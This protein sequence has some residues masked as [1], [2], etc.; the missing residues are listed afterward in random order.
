MTKKIRHVGK[1]IPTGKKIAVVFMQIPGNENQALVCEYESFPEKLQSI[2]LNALY[3]NEAQSSMSLADILNKTYFH[4]YRMNLLQYLH[5]SGKL[6][7]LDVENVLMI[8]SPGTSIKL[9]VLIEE[10]KKLNMQQGNNTAT[11]PTNVQNSVTNDEPVPISLDTSNIEEIAK[12]M[13]VEVEYLRGKA[14]KL[15]K[16]AFALCP[17]LTVSSENK[18]Q[19]EE[20]AQGT[21]FPVIFD[22]T[23]NNSTDALAD[24]TTN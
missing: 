3:S 7:C 24:N 14:D 17:A 18:K 22:T 9:P 5:S 13:L 2:F 23:G 10:I 6:Y 21:L 20:E 16:E 4:E 12:G 19:E 1:S 15:E 11:P 8:P